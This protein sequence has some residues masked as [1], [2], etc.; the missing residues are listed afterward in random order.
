MKI[1]YGLFR[2]DGRIFTPERDDDTAFM[3]AY[4]VLPEN[5]EYVPRYRPTVYKPQ[6]LAEL[7][8]REF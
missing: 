4:G 5:G 2:T 1:I 6:S 3:I 7:L 8:L